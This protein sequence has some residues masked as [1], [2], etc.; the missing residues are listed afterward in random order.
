MNFLVKSNRICRIPANTLTALSNSTQS[1]NVVPKEDSPDELIRTIEEIQSVK[2]KEITK[3]PQRPPFVKNLFLSR[4]D[5]DILTYP[6]VLNSENVKEFENDVK[7]A[8]EF[9]KV[10]KYDGQR[11][12]SSFYLNNLKKLKLLGLRVPYTDGGRQLSVTEA[13]RISEIISENTGR[14]GI[15]YNENLGMQTISKFGT[16]A[17]KKKYLPKLIDGKMVAA[18]SLWESSM[19]PKVF[20][21]TAKLSEDKKTWVC[22]EIVWVYVVLINFVCRY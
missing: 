20:N 7:T 2:T 17:Q 14:I 13:C 18:F 11:K 21:T 19:G 15:S 4:F 8:E 5:T 1:T 9:L 6:E 22:Y 16:E 10:S 3:K 12:I